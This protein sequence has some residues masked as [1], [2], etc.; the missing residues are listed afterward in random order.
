MEDLSAERH[1]VYRKIT[2]ILSIFTALLIMKMLENNII[3]PDEYNTVFLTFMFV[4]AVAAFM[5]LLFKTPK[6][7][8]LLLFVF[9]SCAVSIGNFNN[10][11]FQGFFNGMFW[12]LFFALMLY[13]HEREFQKEN[14][15]V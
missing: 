10:G 4:M 7:Q 8:V 6:K 14:N 13:L 15:I 11:T 2:V 1:S 5:H 12:L 9:A 3:S